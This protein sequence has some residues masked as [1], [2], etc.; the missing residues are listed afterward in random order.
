MRDKARLALV[1]GLNFSHNK[2]SI[3]ILGIVLQQLGDHSRIP[4][5]T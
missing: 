4:H 5:L 3:D 1:S 2:N